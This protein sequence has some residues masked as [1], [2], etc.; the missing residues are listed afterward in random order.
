MSAPFPSGRSGGCVFRTVRCPDP[1]PQTRDWERT[2][3]ACAVVA[4]VATVLLALF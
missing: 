1:I 3:G 2:M 4:M